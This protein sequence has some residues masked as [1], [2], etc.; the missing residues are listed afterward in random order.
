[1]ADVKLFS[2]AAVA[3]TFATRP[4]REAP[5]ANEASL[6]DVLPHGEVMTLGGAGVF[7]AVAT[8]VGAV[9]VRRPAYGVA[10]LILLD[11]FALYRYVGPTTLTLPKAALIG[12][13]IG[14]A[15]RRVDLRPLTD[16]AARPLLYGALAIVA[17][18]ALSGVEAD[19][20]APVVRETSKALEYLF[21]FA[22]VVLALSDD[23]DERPVWTA[24]IAIALVV[25]ALALR[26]EFTG[27]QSYVAI[28]ARV[29]AR[30]AGPLEGPNQLSAYLG[31]LIPVLLAALLGR[32]EAG[33]GHRLRAAALVALPLAVV[34]DV[35]TFSRAGVLSAIVASLIV[36]AALR[37]RALAASAAAV[38]LAAVALALSGPSGGPLAHFLSAREAD[39]PSGLGTR[40]E[41]WRAA[42][43][44]WERHPLLGVGAGNFELELSRVGLGDVH[45]HANSLYLQSLAEGGIP[46]LS[47]WLWTIW[48]SLATFVKPARSATFVAGVLGASAGLA[49]HQTV[50]C[51]TFY[52]KVGVMW[53]LLLGIGTVRAGTTSSSDAGEAQTNTLHRTVS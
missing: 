7:A 52:P 13:L 21:A 48:A 1:M 6:R 4:P 45:T 31:L 23:R 42:L 36:V 26:E 2:R 9:T 12:L 40:S 8:G 11:P 37:P 44:L 47:A 3:S 5:R 16:R 46:L 27:A 20:V 32:R 43:A 24:C 17:A 51:L 19:F 50:D 18:T 22:G 39:T 30:I 28:G 38:A 49:L 34:S 35:L 25:S 14:L 33:I 41:L 53:F 29:V 10:G 15:F